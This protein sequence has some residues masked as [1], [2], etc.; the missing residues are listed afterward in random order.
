[1]AKSGTIVFGRPDFEFLIQ[2]LANRFI[3]IENQGTQL[4]CGDFIPQLEELLL[5][6]IKQELEREEALL[7]VNDLERRDS[8][9][10]RG[11]CLKHDGTEEVR[12]D[13]IRADNLP[14]G[15]QIEE[16]VG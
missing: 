2:I 11:Q 13:V 7:A 5:S 16:L 15:V 12:P 9:V 4:L 1:M 8:S 6:S 3:R 10:L 14:L